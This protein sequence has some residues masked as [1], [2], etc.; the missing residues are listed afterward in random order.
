MEIRTERRK[1]LVIKTDQPAAGQR[2]SKEEKRFIENLVRQRK[3][4][5]IT[6]KD[7]AKMTGL[8]QAVIGRLESM[9]ANPTLKTIVKIVN[10]MDLNLMI[11][12]KE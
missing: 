9:R 4:M 5:K 10:A 1:S 8:D 2:F 6:Q 12:D 3:K 11:A 7:L